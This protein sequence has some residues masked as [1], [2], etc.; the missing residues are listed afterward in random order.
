M[1]RPGADKSRQGRPTIARRFI[2]GFR[3]F[4]L[5]ICSPDRD[6]RTAARIGR[7][8]GSQGAVFRPKLDSSRRWRVVRRSDDDAGHV[9]KRLE[10]SLSLGRAS[11]TTR[12]HVGA[13][14]RHRPNQPEAQRRDQP[15]QEM[16]RP[17]AVALRRA[18]R[19]AR[20]RGLRRA[21]TGHSSLHRS[22]SSSRAMAL[23]RISSSKARPSRPT[24]S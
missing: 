5:A 10:H 18:L 20:R 7:P 6:D 16:L 11:G 19:R 14:T 12:A 23:M 21:D 17:G 3:G 24:R 2:A 9:T 4:S 22:R 13:R 8:L 1:L 15:L